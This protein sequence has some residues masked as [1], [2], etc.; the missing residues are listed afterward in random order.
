MVG[1]NK[2]LNEKKIH[3]NLSTTITLN[4]LLT[5]IFKWVQILKIYF[6]NAQTC[7]FYIKEKMQKVLKFVS[8]GEIARV[9]SFTEDF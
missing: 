4:D 5:I 3:I 1:I 9:S 6:T 7:I 8:T 2:S